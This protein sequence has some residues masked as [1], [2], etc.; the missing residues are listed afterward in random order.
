LRAFVNK[1]KDQVDPSGLARTE[2]GL[3]NINKTSGYSYA[4][5]QVQGLLGEA[6]AYKELKNQGY[7][8]TTGNKYFDLATADGRFAEVR[9]RKQVSINDIFNKAIL[10]YMS[11]TKKTY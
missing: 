11:T 4:I 1:Y 5:N 7:K 2:T 3:K 10:Q 6:E 8:P 9:T